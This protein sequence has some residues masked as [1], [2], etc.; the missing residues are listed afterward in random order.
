MNDKEAIQNVLRPA[1]KRIRQAKC[2]MAGDIFTET[3]RY[4]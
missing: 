3:I 4:N 1:V 2:R